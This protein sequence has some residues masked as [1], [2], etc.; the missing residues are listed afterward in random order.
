LGEVLAASCGR[1]VF[2][3][4]PGGAGSLRRRTTRAAAFAALLVAAAAV[5]FAQA[6][7]PSRPLQFIVPWGPGGGSDQAGREIA[8]RLSN[9]LKQPIPVLNMPG[10]TGT[11]GT[12]KV[13]QSP[14][15][16]YTLGLMAADT[17]ALLAADKPPE[18][19][20]DADLVPLAVMIRQTSAIMVAEDGKYKTW[21]DFEKAA[22]ANPDRL[23]IAVGGI[24][25]P[26]EIAIN[27][28]RARGVQVLVVPYDKPGERY[29]AVLGGQ[30]DAFYEAVGNVRNLLD[31]KK[32]RPILM[33]C[34]KRMPQ[35]PDVPCSTEVGIDI[36]LPQFRSVVVRSDTPAP[37]VRTLSDALAKVAASA[38]YKAYLQSQYADEDSY[39]PADKALTFMHEQLDAMKKIVADTKKK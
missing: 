39:V 19:W 23:S 15:D 14:P 18:Q 24:G 34:T 5:A 7:Y 1:E 27:A 36:T 9:T 26:Q 4:S 35:F 2:R 25:S 8:L 12:A 31:S 29:A 37:I 10:A 32:M 16:G 17:Y 38:E 3:A 22:R 30:I 33:F 13:V 21:A 20:K 28:L 11:I 6:G